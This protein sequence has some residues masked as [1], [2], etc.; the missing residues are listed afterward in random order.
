MRFQKQLLKS[1]SLAIQPQVQESM[2]LSNLHLL[3]TLLHL[4]YPQ[5]LLMSWEGPKTKACWK[6]LASVTV[7]LVRRELPFLRPHQGSGPKKWAVI[8]SE[9]ELSMVTSCKSQ[10][11]SCRCSKDPKS[12]H[13]TSS[14]I[15]LK[16]PTCAQSKASTTQW[17]SVFSEIKKLRQHLEA[18][19]LKAT[20]REVNRQTRMRKTETICHWWQEMQSITSCRVSFIWKMR[21]SS[22]LTC[23]S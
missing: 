2:I 23:S 3:E 12:R 17:A 1:V 9:I 5:K 8:T 7:F 19:S 6:S 22:R 20:C 11:T 4:N 13:E 14:S 21:K 15:T 16:C 10:F 18:K